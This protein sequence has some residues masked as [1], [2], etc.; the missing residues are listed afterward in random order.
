MYRGEYRKPTSEIHCNDDGKTYVRASEIT[1]QCR[2]RGH[3]DARTSLC[4]GLTDHFTVCVYFKCDWSKQSMK[5]KYEI[6][7]FTYEFVCR[8]TTSL[9]MSR[10]GWLI[11]SF[12]ALLVYFCRLYITHIVNSVWLSPSSFHS[13]HCRIVFNNI[14]L[15]IYGIISVSTNIC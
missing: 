14:L 13:P 8:G 7:A 5:I 3:M 9:V 10:A 2:L 11:F 15:F 4:H 12:L 1:F 6:T